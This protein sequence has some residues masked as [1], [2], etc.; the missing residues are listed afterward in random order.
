MMMAAMLL[1]RFPEMEMELTKYQ[2][3]NTK[4]QKL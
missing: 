1:S 4:N 2:K 3:P